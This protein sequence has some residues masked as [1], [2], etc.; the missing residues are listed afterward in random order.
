MAGH[1]SAPPWVLGYDPGKHG[2]AATL[3]DSE[4]KARAVWAWRSRTRGGETCF[5]VAALQAEGG[6]TP[7]L[8]MRPT[9]GA[10]GDLVARQAA[11]ITGAS[12]W[13][14]W[15]EAS[16]LHGGIRSPAT[17][18]RMG[19][20][21]GALVG[22]VERYA[23][24]RRVPQVQAAEWRHKLL[25]LPIRTPRDRAKAASLA[26]VP[27]RIPGIGDAL[28]ALA[29]AYNASTD[30]LDHVTDSAGVAEY[31]ARFGG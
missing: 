14:V 3:L 5:Q 12:R 19:Q 2:G 21:T 10:V 27:N 26:L 29:D 31:A 30:T 15:C 1:V 7:S 28:R 18:I 13:R 9:L 16:H 11:A 8:A 6:W 24:G 4:L 17:A 22:P 25:G 20:I 23:D